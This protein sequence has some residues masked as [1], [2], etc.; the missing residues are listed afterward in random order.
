MFK[1]KANQ[2]CFYWSYKFTFFQGEEKKSVEKKPN[3]IKK[4]KEKKKGHCNKKKNS[5]YSGDAKAIKLDKNDKTWVREE[6]LKRNKFNLSICDLKT[7]PKNKKKVRDTGS[8]STKKRNPKKKERE[9]KKANKEEKEDDVKEND[10]DEEMCFLILK[11]RI[12]EVVKNL[13]TEGT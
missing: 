5:L 13:K 8:I 3:I 6:K 12:H 7:K 2:S 4:E 10:F 9:K 1:N 11:E